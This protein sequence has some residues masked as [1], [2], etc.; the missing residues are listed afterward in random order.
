MYNEL[1]LTIYSY[2]THTSEP[3]AV[4]HLQLGVLRIAHNLDPGRKRILAVSDR[5]VL[6]N[7]KSSSHAKN[8]VVSPSIHIK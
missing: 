8:T 3:I 4:F 1:L 6:L 7:V 2:I 5:H